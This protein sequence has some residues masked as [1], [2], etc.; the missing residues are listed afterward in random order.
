MFPIKRCWP[1]PSLGLFQSLNPVK[2]NKKTVEMRSFRNSQL[3]ETNLKLSSFV[4]LEY[5]L[6]SCKIESDK[7]SNNCKATVLSLPQYNIR[8]PDMAKTSIQQRRKKRGAAFKKSPEAPKRFRS[9][10]ILFFTHIH[11]SVKKKLP[12]DQASVSVYCTRG[13]FSFQSSLLDRA[14]LNNTDSTY[15]N[16][17]IDLDN[18]SLYRR[19]LL[20]QKKP[21]R[22]GRISQN[23][24][25]NIGTMWPLRRRSIT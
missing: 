2:I 14:N 11:D 19:L 18:V 1:A 4:A 6:H 17:N 15:I 16:S 23:S 13:T 7:I 3:T 24:N 5:N 25:D 10:Y 9:S 20:F 22:C 8:V 21:Q 12:R